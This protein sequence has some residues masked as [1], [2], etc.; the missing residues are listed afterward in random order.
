MIAVF[1]RKGKG[2]GAGF[3]GEEKWHINSHI[4]YRILGFICFYYICIYTVYRCVSFTH[5]LCNIAYRQTPRLRNHSVT[6]LHCISD[7]MRDVCSDSSQLCLHIIVALLLLLLE[8]KVREWGCFWP[9][10]Y[11]HRESFFFF[12]SSWQGLG[13]FTLQLT[14]PRRG[15]YDLHGF[16]CWE[17]FWHFLLF[18]YYYGYN[19]YYNYFYAPKL[20]SSSE[21]P[22]PLLTPMLHFL[23]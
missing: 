19:F 21:Q 11:L 5:T 23:H 8:V 2:E 9:S 16:S 18:L 22:R 15:N 20:P 6:W 10:H 13:I 14:Q 3:F 1:Q 4:S 7:F 12:F 17:E